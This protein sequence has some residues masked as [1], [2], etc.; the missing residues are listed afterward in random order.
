MTDAVLNPACCAKP[1]VVTGEY[2]PKGTYEDIGGFKTYISGPSTSTAALI[3]IHDIFGPVS[4]IIQGADRLAASTGQ[5]ILTPDFFN[6]KR[7]AKD[8]FPMDTDEK[9]ATVGKF[10]AEVAGF[11]EG[12]KS[13]LAV[14]NAGSEKFSSVT[15]W[16]AFGLCWGGKVTALASAEG[17]LFKA[18]GTAHPG[19]L[20]I[21]EAHGI[22]I[23]YIC[24][25][26]KDEDTD[27]GREYGKVLMSNP[28]AKGSVFETYGTMHHGWMGAKADLENEENAKEYVRGYEQASEFFKALLV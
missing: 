26:S 16:G 12:T 28:K 9:Q 2:T 14:R 4:Q 23:P 22:T 6:G 24:L 7:L 20:A 8:L 25:F 17:S 1:A 5:L 11:E 3:L 21:D 10:F 19:R 18:A 13:L 15:A 27:L